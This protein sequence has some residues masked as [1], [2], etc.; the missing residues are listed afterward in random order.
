MDKYLAEFIGTFFLCFAVC[1]AAAL[2]AAGTDAAY[3]IAFTLMAMIYAGGPI[4]KAHFNPAV[5][6]GFILRGKID[7]RD[8]APY[9][10]AQFAAGILASLLALFVFKQE[11]EIELVILSGGDILPAL[12]A[13]ILFSFA[14]VWVILHV[15][16][17]SPTAGNQWFG[18]A[19]AATVLGGALTVGTYSLAVFNPAVAAALVL[20]GKLCLTCIWIPV[21]GSLLGGAGAALT[22]KFMHPKE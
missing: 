12:V 1:V 18:L 7:R 9:L 6:L 16:T 21:M 17:Y 14:L 20:V 11:R 10:I 13:E 2:G 22:F 4:S 8:I 19:I 3:A 5:T 15:A